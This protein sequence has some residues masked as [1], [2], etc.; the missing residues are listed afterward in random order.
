MQ[1]N[2]RRLTTELLSYVALRGKSDLQFSDF[3][4]DQ[5]V[6]FEDVYRSNGG[7]SGWSQ[8]KRDA[9]LLATTEGPE[10]DYFGRRFSD[11]LHIDDPEQLK[12]LRR[13]SESPVTYTT[14]RQDEK[15]RL[16][17]LAYQID[18]QREKVG[19]AEEFVSRL[20]MNPD[21]RAE[22]GALGCILASRTDLLAVPVPG[23]EDTP[24]KLYAHYGIREIL[25]AVGF[26]SAE[27]RKMFREGVLALK[28]RSTELLFVTLDKSDVAH[29]SVAYRDYA[30]SPD[31]FSPSGSLFRIRL[32]LILPLDVDIWIPP[33]Q[34]VDIFNSS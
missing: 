22:L 30:V 34:R 16:Q 24:L 18:G 12:L 21:I 23:L 5:H 19:S 10:E 28:A 17:M 6:E 31:L 33:H 32:G 11:L 2:W 4:H 20:N 7:R 13:F 8:L 14:W 27:N 25:T 15:L 1:Q 26:Y 9:G 3:L 29:S